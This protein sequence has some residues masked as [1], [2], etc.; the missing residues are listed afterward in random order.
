[1]FSTVTYLGNSTH[2]TL[3]TRVKYSITVT[4]LPF[5]Q[6]ESSPYM[7]LRSGNPVRRQRDEKYIHCK[8]GTGFPPTSEFSFTQGFMKEFMTDD[9]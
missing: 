7:Q 8:I 9:E 3:M 2:Y 1:M 4:G 5:D 6:M